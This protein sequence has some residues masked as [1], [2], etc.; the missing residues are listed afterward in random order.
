MFGIPPVTAYE[1]A[2]H[3]RASDYAR[4]GHGVPYI[5]KRGRWAED[6]S[7]KR[8]EKSG[9]VQQILNEYHPRTREYCDWCA[10]SLEGGVFQT[11]RTPAA[12]AA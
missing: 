1:V 11:T 8:Y 10:R 12:S 6:T 9:G 2:R 5:Q 4:E 3:A 7:C